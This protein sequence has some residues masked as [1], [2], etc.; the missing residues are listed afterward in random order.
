MTRFVDDSV[1]C[2]DRVDCLYVC[3]RCHRYPPYC[4]QT[5]DLPSGVRKPGRSPSQVRPVPGTKRS[6]QP[7]LMDGRARALLDSAPGPVEDDAK[8]K[9]R[10]RPRPLA[11]VTTS[12][13]CFVT[14]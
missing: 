11:C 4:F 14:T 7:G 12:T 1:V 9:E 3:C 10:S 5:V 6:T 8:R 13:M 2:V